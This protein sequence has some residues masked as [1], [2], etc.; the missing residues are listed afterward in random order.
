MAH[1]GQVLGEGTQTPGQDDPSSTSLSWAS[2]HSSSQPA[3]QY[4]PCVKQ[5]GPSGQG[6]P[7]EPG[8][9]GQGP[10]LW[11]RGSGTI[12]RASLSR[13]YWLSARP[14]P[15]R[16]GGPALLLLTEKSS[17]ASSY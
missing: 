6:G 4:M 7:G 14:H 17:N 8:R 15:P 3:D 9:W 11:S 16:P 13:V 5:A 2:S 12:P 10:Q 1:P